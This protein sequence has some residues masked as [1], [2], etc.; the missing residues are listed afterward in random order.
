MNPKLAEETRRRLLAAGVLAS[1]ATLL[2]FRV[3]WV[4]PQR[5][6]LAMRRVELERSRDEIVQARRDAGRL[7]G[8][9]AE[10]GR[11]RRRAA[12]LRRALPEPPDA[13]AVLRGLH[14]IAE[15]SGLTMEA[16]TVEAIRVGEQF[17]EWPVRLELTGEFHELVAFL[18]ATRRL[19]RIVTVG[20]MSIRALPAGTGAATIA[21]TCTATTYVV[22][23]SVEEE[24][25]RMREG[26]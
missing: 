4:G 13:S 10:V 5:E 19:P 1:L 17:E 20:P 6:F 14:G 23:E 11:L 22:R 25:L 16:F 2:A 8:L 21:V 9:E 7:P 15:Q 24:E 18:D 26:G 3:F 12:A